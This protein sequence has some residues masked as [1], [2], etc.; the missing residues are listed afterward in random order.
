MENIFIYYF[1]QYIKDLKEIDKCDLSPIKAVEFREKLFDLFKTLIIQ[2]HDINQTNEKNENLLLYFFDLTWG[3]KLKC[4]KAY[5]KDNLYVFNK[6]CSLGVSTNVS[7]NE[8]KGKKK[9]EYFQIPFILCIIDLIIDV[10]ESYDLSIELLHPNYFPYDEEEGTRMFHYDPKGRPFNFTTSKR[11]NFMKLKVSHLHH[12][13]N[14]ALKDIS[15]IQYL[16]YGK[17]IDM[18]L[19]CLR[20]YNKIYHLRLI[21]SVNDFMK[22]IFYKKVGYFI[23]LCKALMKGTFR[24]RNVNINRSLIT[25]IHVKDI[26]I[27]ICNFVYID[28][29]ITSIAWNI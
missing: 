6:L 5:G 26:M 23:L 16:Y 7:F 11:E 1:K 29:E 9:K 12:V 18:Y 4:F 28:D 19:D 20:L 10:I 27:H 8:I 3:G 21:K 15:S 17:K 2:G 22:S 13:L 14:I 24:Y 25:L